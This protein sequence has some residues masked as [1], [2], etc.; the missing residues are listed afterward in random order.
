[1]PF[2]RYPLIERLLVAVVAVSGAMSCGGQSAV[3]PAGPTS[4]DPNTP[5]L[6]THTG[7]VTIEY[8]SANFPPGFTLPG[9]GA[10]ISGCAG[11]LR[12]TF[13]L[14]NAGT[15]G[16][17]L[18]TAAWLHGA[19]KVPCMSFVGPPFQ[20]PANSSRLLDAVFDQADPNCTLPFETTDLAVNVEG[21]VG[22]YGRQEF[23]IR[24]RFTQ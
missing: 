6:G 5:R 8:L 11:L 15:G 23:G 7:V 13:R 18:R 16:N 14:T 21:S 9:C 22:A 24:Y 20:F 10:T 12:L 4:F 1:V 2:V 3:P 17:V 19:D